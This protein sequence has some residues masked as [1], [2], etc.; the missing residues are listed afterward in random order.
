M[1]AGSAPHPTASDLA[2][3][4]AIAHRIVWCTL[5]TVDARGRP[6]SRLVHPLWTI[7]TDGSLV[8]RITSRRSSP[9]AA[10]L[11]AHPYAS[12][13]Y[14]DP[15]HDVAV[16]ECRAA[17]DPDPARSWHLFTEPDPPVGF[18]PAAMFAGGLASPDAGIVVLRPWRLRW[19]RAASLATG[20]KP[21][22]RSAGAAASDRCAR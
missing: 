2:E 8:G 6:R 19:G 3:F 5:A 21:T 17:W 20:A 14:W 12:C 18:D 13:S 16:A 22:V 10:H 11:T 7:E 4:V 1:S 15:Q 9:K